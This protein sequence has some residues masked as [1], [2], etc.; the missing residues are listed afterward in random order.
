MSTARTGSLLWSGLARSDS[1]V[2]LDGRLYVAVEAC[3]LN[4]PLQIG[5]PH[6][7]RFVLAKAL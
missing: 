3:G 7:V 5:Q 6:T 4:G 1:G 2:R